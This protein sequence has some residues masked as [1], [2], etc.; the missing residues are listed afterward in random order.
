VLVLEE[1]LGCACGASTVKSYTFVPVSTRFDPAPSKIPTRPSM[2][3][4]VFRLYGSIV[5][6]DAVGRTIVMESD[7]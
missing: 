4:Y 3:M 1:T 6:E 7:G 5:V 2:S